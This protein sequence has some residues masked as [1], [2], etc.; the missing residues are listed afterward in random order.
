M[1]RPTQKST[2]D[3]QRDGRPRP[4]GQRKESRSNGRVLHTDC[5]RLHRRG[6]HDQRPFVARIVDTALVARTVLTME[7]V[8]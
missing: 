5:A 1:G 4:A 8:S 2:G 6:S 7:F 3:R